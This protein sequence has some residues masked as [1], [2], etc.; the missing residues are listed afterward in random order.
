[1]PGPGPRLSI[2]GCRWRTARARLARGSLRL[3]PKPEEPQAVPARS[4]DRPRDLGETQ[5]FGA[6]IA[7][8]VLENVHLVSTSVP[9]TERPLAVALAPLVT[10]TVEVERLKRSNLL[11]HPI[12]LFHAAGSAAMR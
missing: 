7:K 9:L 4:G 8:A 5:V 12:S 3:F 11:R 1:M 6:I 2:C 10:K